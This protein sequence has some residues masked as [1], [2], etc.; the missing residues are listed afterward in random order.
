MSQRY[1]RNIVEK[2]KAPDIP[3]QSLLSPNPNDPNLFPIIK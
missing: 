3:L 1:L 2:D